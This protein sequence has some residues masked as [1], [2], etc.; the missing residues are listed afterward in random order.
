MRHMNINSIFH[1]SSEEK[2]CEKSLDLYCNNTGRD[3]FLEKRSRPSFIFPHL[4]SHG[5]RNRLL[6]SSHLK[7][8]ILSDIKVT[9]WSIS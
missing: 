4:S 1:C 2:N 3:S 9:I 6:K 7:V 5:L 8:V